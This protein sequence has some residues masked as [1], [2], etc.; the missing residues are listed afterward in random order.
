V[1]L[2][3][4]VFAAWREFLFFLI[5]VTCVLVVA[6][7]RTAP[8]AAQVMATEPEVKAAFLYN[9]ARF[10]RWPEE[11]LARAAAFPICVLGRDPIEPMLASAIAGK[12]VGDLPIVTKRLDAGSSPSDCRILFISS[13]AENHLDE[14]L[15]DVRGAGVLT[16]ADIDDFAERGGMIR[17]RLD[18][19]RMRLDVNIEAAEGA[20][21][22]ISSQ[23]LKLANIVPEEG[24]AP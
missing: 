24:G 5:G 10:V 1:R 22:K 7:G 20:H 16:V 14:V 13:S 11:T 4:G 23:L 8:V 3:L 21:L 19:K 9:F 18:G 2:V 12:R 15:K 6:L 17:F